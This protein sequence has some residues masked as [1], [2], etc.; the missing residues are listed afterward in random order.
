[1][2]VKIAFANGEDTTVHDRE[3]CENILTWLR[4]SAPTLGLGGVVSGWDTYLVR[5]GIAY[6][7]VATR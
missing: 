4:G 7:Q 2:I 6:V 3:T 5:T 1:M